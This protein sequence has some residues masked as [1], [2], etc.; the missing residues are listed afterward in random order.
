MLALYRSGRQAEALRAYAQL[1]ER[2]G[3][4]LGID[5]DVALSRLETAI[6]RHEPELDLE[7]RR[8]RA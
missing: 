7:V 6:V 2:L 4:G 5:P 8:I 3:E 1:R